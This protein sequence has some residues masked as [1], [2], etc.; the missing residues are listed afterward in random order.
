MKKT[1]IKLA[2]M[3]FVAVMMFACSNQ[4]EESKAKATSENNEPQT[5][6]KIAYINADSLTSQYK[7]CKDYSLILEKK[8]KNIQATLNSKAQALQSAAAN[9]QQKLQQNAYTRERA[10]QVQ[11]ALQ[12]QEADLQ[13][14]QQ[15]LAADFENEQAKF[16]I[17]F[18]DSVKN[19]LKAY[20]KKKKYDLILNKAAILEG[21]DK[22]DITDEIVK[23]LNKAY[24]PAKKD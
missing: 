8:E 6:L 5:G 11:A 23:G 10:E 12:K 21:S 15:R 19:Y 24:K 17:A 16:L 3:A 2:S 13:A 1:I 4:G 20:N 9:F 14:L 18:Q 7:F 22:F